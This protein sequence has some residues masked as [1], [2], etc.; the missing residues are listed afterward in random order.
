[1]E[2]TVAHDGTSQDP[3]QGHL[4][5][6]PSRSGQVDHEPYSETPV[7]TPPNPQEENAISNTGGELTSGAPAS[8]ISVAEGA[9]VPHEA[10]ATLDHVTVD[11]SEIA[12]AGAPSPTIVCPPGAGTSV[13]PNSQSNGFDAP[14][15]DI[16]APHPASTSAT[17]ETSPQGMP[18][19]PSSP[20]IGAVSASPFDP[21]LLSVGTEQSS[22]RQKDALDAQESDGFVIPASATA[23]I[24]QDDRDQPGATTATEVACASV[25]G[26]E[27]ASPAHEA[28][29]DVPVFSP[30]DMPGLMAPRVEPAVPALVF[31]R[32]SLILGGTVAV[33]GAL[34]L[35]EHSTI[36]DRPARP[37]IT[38]ATAVPNATP[39]EPGMVD[40]L[41][42][43]RAAL[44]AHDV[45]ALAGMIDPDGLVVGPYSGGTPE[46]GYPISE[47]RSFLANVVTDARLVTPGWRLD[48]RGRIFLLVDGWR[49]RPL[50][51][52]PNSTLE[53][54]PLAAIVM[55]A[56]SGI[57]YVRWFLIDATG[58]LTQQ[59]RN[60]TWQA[61]P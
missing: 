60:V 40:A 52:S 4:T 51:L 26:D 33:L 7:A 1:M 11:G 38:V 17:R 29:I 6:V 16:T 24:P 20:E 50:S 46:S 15:A 58:M 27:L 45:V 49:T 23:Q 55:Q 28:T 10:E 35:W 44:V 56:R 30:T 8:P 12:R 43:V 25:G 59:A 39:L 5:R 41:R 21:P 14:R 36:P 13:T 47:S 57:W 19:P 18:T 2:R 32:R 42:K 22:Q 34:T 9:L 54:T 61:L 48:S 37:I 31:W 53:L 3:D